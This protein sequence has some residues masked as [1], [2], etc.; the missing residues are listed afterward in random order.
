MV[1]KSTDGGETFTDPVAAAQL[2]DGF[3]DTAYSAVGDQ[4]VFGH[5]MRWASAGN[6]S[7]NPQNPQDVTVVWSDRG[8]ANP[9]ATDGCVD[10]APGDPPN[11]DPCDAGPGSD[12]NIY[13]SRST[14]GGVTWTGRQL[15][16]GTV[17]N[18]WYPWADHKPNGTLAVA[19]D[20]DSVGPLRPIPSTTCSR[21]GRRSAGPRTEHV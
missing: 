19:R 5:Q 10:N 8:T 21:S 11:Y 13:F 6:I 9:N 2:E 3:S 12:L 7:V 4:T 20:Q 16:D 14:D 1:V 18:G 15:L 17:G